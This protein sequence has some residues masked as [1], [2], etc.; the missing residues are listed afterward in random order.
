VYVIDVTR[1]STTRRWTGARPSTGSA[2][3]VGAPRMPRMRTVTVPPL[4]PAPPGHAPAGEGH[5]YEACCLWCLAA[6]SVS[7]IRMEGRVAALIDRIAAKTCTCACTT[8]TLLHAQPASLSP[9]HDSIPARVC[10]GVLQKEW[11]VGEGQS[12]RVRHHR[13]LLHACL[14][15]ALGEDRGRVRWVVG[16]T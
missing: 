3:P 2:R 6:V 5:S 12:Q 7:H 4:A 11:R 10:A 13:G 16:F 9:S 1:Q 15:Q 8:R 14:Q